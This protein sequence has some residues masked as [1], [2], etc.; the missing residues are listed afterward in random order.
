MSHAHKDETIF[1][2]NA[3]IVMGLMVG[4]TIAAVG[5]YRL[6]GFAPAG[7]ETAPVVDT[8]ALVFA[9]GERGA[10]VV[11][12]PAGDTVLNTLAPQ[13]SGFMRNVLRAFGRERGRAG[14]TGAAPLELVRRSNDRL[15]VRD[16]Q[17]GLEIHLG[18]FTPESTAQFHRLLETGRNDT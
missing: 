8:R 5:A 3:L 2:R 15:S 7:R 6:A 10:I 13:D 17:T 4:V 16:P 12:D 14:L 9:D 18:S 11:I 1:H